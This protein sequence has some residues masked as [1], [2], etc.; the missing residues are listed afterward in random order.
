MNKNLVITARQAC[1]EVGLAVVPDVEHVEE[2]AAK[3]G[4][5]VQ[6]AAALKSRLAIGVALDPGTI[7]V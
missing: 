7:I 6:R 2:L 3:T 4:Q 5:V 1:V